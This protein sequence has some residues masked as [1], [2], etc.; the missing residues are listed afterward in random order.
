MLHILGGVAQFER[1]LIRERQRE[2]IALAK[3]AGVYKGRKPSLTPEQAEKLRE[4]A[5][6][7]EKKTMLAAEFGIS[8]E[9]LYKYLAA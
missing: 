5:K 8:R 7:G 9:T 2:G 1:S 4:R 3:K 6:S